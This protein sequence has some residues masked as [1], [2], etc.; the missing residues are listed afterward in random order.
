MVQEMNNITGSESYRIVWPPQD[1]INSLDLDKLTPYIASAVSMTDH[2][3]GTCRMGKDIDPDKVV[4]DR[5]R[6][7]GV[8]G[9][10]CADLSVLPIIPDGNTC[11]GAYAV[12]AKCFEFL[13]GIQL[14]NSNPA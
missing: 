13:T 10:R 2:A 5:L 11:Y 3:T 9:L 7:V 6:V 14:D 8:R 4:D 1:V 12:G